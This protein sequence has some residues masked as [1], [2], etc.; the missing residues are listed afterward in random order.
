ME[1]RLVKR[2]LVSIKIRPIESRGIVGI[3]SNIAFRS[4]DVQGEQSSKGIDG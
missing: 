1:R 3:V 2:A 4:D